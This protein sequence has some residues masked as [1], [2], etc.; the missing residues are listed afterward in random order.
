MVPV[1]L[2]FIVLLSLLVVLWAGMIEPNS[3]RV[4]SVK[5]KVPR[6]Y[7]HLHGLCIVQISDLHFHKSVPQ[8]FLRKVSKEIA[9]L[10][11]DILLFSGDFLCRAQVEDPDRLEAFLH[12]L[13]ARLGTFAVLGNHDYQSYVSRNHHGEIDVIPLESSQPLKRIFVSIIQA[14]FSSNR[15]KFAKTL[16]PQMPHPELIALL[17]K[18]PI[19]LLHNENYTIPDVANIV[20]LGDIFARQCNPEQA[21]SNYNPTLPGIILSH[22]PDTITLL[23]NHSGDLVFSGHTHGPQVS[24][25]W[26]KFANKIMNRLSGL[27]NPNLTRGHFHFV[28]GLKQLYVN[29]GLGG[30]KRL[31]FC[32]P[33]EICC[34]RCEYGT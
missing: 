22:N 9:S 23:D 11:P 30:L 33:P 4:S 15:Y 34:V 13:K 25:P 10:S 14:L 12:T 28:D 5:W 29:R 24:L 7:A 17:K 6:K 18:T 8:K 27:E 3:L 19:T 32:S 31:R 2:S 26:P 20:G 21:F 16:Q 1:A